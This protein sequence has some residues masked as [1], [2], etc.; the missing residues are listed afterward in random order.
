V[1]VGQLRTRGVGFTSLHENFDT[2]TPG[3]RLVSR[4]SQPAASLAGTT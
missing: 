2:T 4:Q 1:A 3:G